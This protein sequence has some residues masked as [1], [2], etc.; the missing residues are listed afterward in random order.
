MNF[1]RKLAPIA[2]SA[3]FLGMTAGVAA[4]ND[5]ANYPAPF[6]SGGVADVGI[7][8][9]SQS[10]ATA[11]VLAAVDIATN[12]QAN[13]AGVGGGSGGVSSGEG[14]NLATSNTKLYYNSNLDSARTTLTKSELPNVLADGKVID[15]NGNEYSYTQSIAVGNSTISFSNS[16]ADLVDPALLIDVGTTALDPIYRYDVAFSK[17]INV[18]SPDV[19]GNNIKIMG[20]DFT[21]GASSTNTTLYLYGVGTGVT[22]KEGE[23]KTVT[24]GGKDYAVSC[25]GVSSTTVAMIT[26]NGVSKEITEGNIYKFGDLEVYAKNVFYLSK[27]AQVSS[28]EL[29]LGSKRLKIANGAT[30]KQGSDDTTI[31]NTYA[32][33]TA[34]TNAGH[35]SGFKIYQA[36]ETSKLDSIEVGKDYTDR[37]FGTTKVSFKEVI[38]ALDSAAR[39]KIVVDTDNNLNARV[40]FTDAMTG[41]E[42]TVY[43]AHDTD[44]SESTVTPELGDSS[45]YDIITVEGQNISEGQH[46]IINAG[47]YGR[48]LEYSSKVT[49]DISSTDTIDF[50]DDL[51]GETFKVYIGQNTP[52]AL[53][54]NNTL[55]IDGQTYYVSLN[56]VTGEIKVT[57]GSGATYSTWNALS[58]KNAGPG[59]AVS[60]FPR[61]KLKNG[62]WLSFLWGKHALTNRTDIILPGEYAKAEDVTALNTTR[63]LT[64]LLTFK[65]DAINWTIN[66]TTNSPFFNVTGIYDRDSRTTNSAFDC[67]FYDSPAILLLE[68]YS[69]AGTDRVDAICIP[70][71]STG[72][73]TVEMFVGKPVFLNSTG[74]KASLVSLTSDTYKQQAVDLFGTFVEYDATDND[75]V[76]IKYPNDQMYANVYISEVAAAISGSSGGIVGGALGD[77]TKW[78]EDISAVQNKNLIVIGGSAVNPA[79]A[80]LLGVPEGTTGADPAWDAATGV[81]Q[82]MAII[83]LFNS[84]YADGKVAMLIAG[85][86]AKDTIAAAKVLTKKTIALSGESALLETVTESSVKLHT[87]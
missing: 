17:D 16:G 60:V 23:N 76:T 43:F 50:T 77:V 44:T 15:D 9:G 30:V 54:W 69:S 20:Q 5:L 80:K 83:K 67:D 71:D 66:G 84:P 12:L 49:G 58:A 37:V 6:V 1:I 42:H 4:A 11:D 68:E 38:P 32:V 70:T 85:W 29:S 57:W 75:K 53:P 34:G 19:Q 36:G 61:I 13:L 87:A 14:V 65:V 25:D 31:K 26:V 45:G 78:Y 39:D 35:I 82:D 74:T 8:L 46:F 7:V 72:T 62:E 79:A 56:N 28:V 51:S 3:L 22:L 59:N 55:N 48:I 52:K 27:E 41:K 24:I 73:T 18:S 21:I 64:N 10:L 86:E 63:D 40:T 2:A 33:V 47:D 81:K